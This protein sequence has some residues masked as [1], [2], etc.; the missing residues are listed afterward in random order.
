MESFRKSVV[1]TGASSGIGRA[2]ALQ[3]ARS[4][5]RV[6]ATVRR[7]DDAEALV[8]ESGDTIRALR[9]DVTDAESIIAAARAV[10]AEV[11]GNGLDGL[12]N[13]AGIGV[14]MPVE[15]TTSEMLR[16]VFE[17][18]L[19]GQIEVIRAFLPMLR[20]A[21]G[22]VVN[23]GSVGDH[24]TPP[25][26]G[27]LASSKAAFAA[28]ST[29]LRLEVRSQGIRVVVI[30]PGS[31]HTPAVTKTLGHVD[32]TIRGLP[33]EGAAHYGDAMRQMSRVFS[34][35]ERAGSPPE[36]VAAV[37][38][39]ALTARRPCTRYPAGKDARKIT[40]LAR[41]LPEKLLDRVIL[42]MFGLA[43]LGMNTVPA[44]RRRVPV[45][46]HRHA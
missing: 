10:H 38:E 43:K 17:I 15:Y 40:M 33:S 3:L 13:N 18:N 26:G 45:P 24:I 1:V 39:R 11:A 42:R 7:D 20:R 44:P 46:R 23:L 22:C 37:I 16:E 27:A 2:T 19:F 8:V 41:V 25:F 5:W 4:G 9:L 30:E 12:V 34:R 28:M 31:I 35:R 14:T 29:A 6:Y 32:E 21:R 36:A